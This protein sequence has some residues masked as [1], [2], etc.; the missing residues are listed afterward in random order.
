M[1][2]KI[3]IWPGPVP[4]LLPKRDGRRHS[5]HPRLH[6]SKRN[7][8][9]ASG[10]LTL[11]R[12][13][14]IRPRH[15]AAAATLE[16]VEAQARRD[17]PPDLLIALYTSIGCDPA[18]PLRPAGCTGHQRCASDG[19]GC[20]PAPSGII[21]SGWGSR[22]R[23]ASSYRCP[24]GTNNSPAPCQAAERSESPKPPAPGLCVCKRSRPKDPR[25]AA[26]RRAS[27]K[28]LCVSVKFLRTR[29]MDSKTYP[30]LECS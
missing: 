11:Y 28:Y 5:F 7:S 23:D 14:L 13:C 10:T 9:D 15:V 4:G 12:Q 18:N 6:V 20:A 19:Q 21:A 22:T 1:A 25:H 2:E 3:T 16:Q 29:S 24:T 17:A 8:N 27:G 30:L 26:L